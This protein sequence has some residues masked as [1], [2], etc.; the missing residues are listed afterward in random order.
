[1][2]IAT[3]AMSIVDIVSMVMPIGRIIMRMPVSAMLAMFEHIAAHVA[4]SAP[5]A[6]S[7]AEH[8]VAAIEQAFM[9]WM[10]SC[11]AVMSIDIPI[12]MPS[13]DIDFIICMVSIVGLPPLTRRAPDRP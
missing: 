5:M 10:Q 1:L 4:M 8:I 6:M 7:A 3:Q 13:I 9:A 11:M 12:G 2:P